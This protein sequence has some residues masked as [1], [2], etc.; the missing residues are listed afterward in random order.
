M[1][2]IPLHADIYNTVCSDISTQ[3][4]R[5]KG[6]SRK[7][8]Q[9]VWLC[10]DLYMDMF[11]NIQNSD[12]FVSLKNPKIQNI[13]IRLLKPLLCDR[14]YLSKPQNIVHILKNLQEIEI[15]GF[16]YDIG[17]SHNFFLNHEPT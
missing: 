13:D 9:N 2:L 3:T 12:I 15:R 11:F 6:K 16:C 1:Y 4:A 17:Y 8:M 5:Q 7:D 14:N 10:K